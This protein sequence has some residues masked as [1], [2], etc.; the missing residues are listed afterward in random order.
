MSRCTVTL[1]GRFI[2]DTLSSDLNLHQHDLAWDCGSY[3]RSCIPTIRCGHP[4]SDVA[5]GRNFLRS[6]RSLLGSTFPTYLESPEKEDMLANRA[7]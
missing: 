7:K 1:H 5:P 6:I 3:P 2:T 4:R